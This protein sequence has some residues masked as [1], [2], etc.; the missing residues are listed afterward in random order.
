MPTEV[1]LPARPRAEIALIVAIAAAIALLHLLTNNRYGFHRDELQFL[2][3]ARHLDWGFVAYPPVTPFL[4]RIAMQLFGLSLVGLR[5]FSVL[6]QAAAIVVTGLIARELGGRRLAQI[7]AALAVALSALPLFEGTEFQ[8]SSFDYLWWVVIAYFVARLLRTEDPRWWLAIGLF[9]GIGLETKYTILFYIAGILVGMLLTSARRYFASPWFYAGVAVALLL[10]LPNFLWQ[11]HH[12]FISKTFL[13]HIHKR[14]VGEGRA[15]G[16]LLQQLFICANSFA[17]P[18]WIVG[19]I[20]ALR[21]PRF[22][23]L[24]WMYLV[25]FA[26]F[27]FGKGRSY[28]L[29]AAYPMLFAM[30]A[31][32]AER[33]LATLQRGWRISIEAVFFTGLALV[34]ALFVAILIPVASSGPLKA[35]ALAHNG[36]LREEIGWDTLL[37][38]LA[39]LRDG[40]PPAQQ[41]SLGIITGNYGEQGAVEILGPPYHLPPPISMTNSAWLRGYPT[42]QPTTLIVL[43]FSR[44]GANR[45]F[46]DCRLA[47]MEFNHEGV[48]NEESQGHDIFVCGPPRLPWAE[49]WRQYQAFG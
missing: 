28:Y 13:E 14:D 37:Q 32:V 8:Y 29:A 39:D 21:S 15:D 48:S 36:D 44:D 40:L 3:D 11:V 1:E 10:F 42:P 26:L 19:L 12:D 5:L 47:G 46:T 31:V 18:L 20:A 38:Q 2:S 9:I 6:A 43:G 7:T 22:R 35:F 24:G 49:F 33:S 4:E 17:T 25:P 27:L 45:T 30:G 16:F 41:D 23:M 34:G